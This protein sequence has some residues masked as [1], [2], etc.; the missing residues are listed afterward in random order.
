MELSC[1]EEESFP[2]LRM[3]TRGP[4]GVESLH[5][6]AWWL[7]DMTPVPVQY[8]RNPGDLAEEGIHSISNLKLKFKNLIFFRVFKFT[9]SIEK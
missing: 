4:Q 6:Q 7:E 2:T 5:L 3:A 1:L 9:L 8:S